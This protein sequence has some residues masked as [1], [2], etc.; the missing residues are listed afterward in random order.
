MS[1]AANSAIEKNYQKEYYTNGT[2]KAEGWE[3]GVTKID[4]WYFYHPNGE[5]ASK[6]SFSKDTKEGYWYYFTEAGTLIKEGH[7]QNG[8][9]QDWWIFYD[10]ATHTENRFQFKNNE[11]NGFALIYKKGSLKRAEEYKNNQKVGE[12]TSIFAFKKDNPHVSF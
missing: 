7:Y 5:I 6:G 3:L 2:L 4:Y 9:A 11:K 10:I 8:I 1:L 12:W